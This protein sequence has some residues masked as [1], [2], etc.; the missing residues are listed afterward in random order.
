MSAG[1]RNTTTYYPPVAPVV[2]AVDNELTRK[3]RITLRES[4]KKLL[5][6]ELTWKRG[7]CSE[8]KMRNHCLTDSSADEESNDLGPSTN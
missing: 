7:L 2:G 4:A 3:K 5:I 8:S 1:K 6:V